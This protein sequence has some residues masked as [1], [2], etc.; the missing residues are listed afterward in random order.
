MSWTT[1]RGVHV[2]VV[3]GQVSRERKEGFGILIPR[4]G[5]RDRRRK[6][7]IK[8]TRGEKERKKEETRLLLDEKI[9]SS[10]KKNFCLY[11]HSFSVH[12][13]GLRIN[14]IVVE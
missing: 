1:D 8:G 14:T 2:F 4:R 12:E 10:R 5:E 9:Q 3:T 7:E 13:L 11:L 6:N